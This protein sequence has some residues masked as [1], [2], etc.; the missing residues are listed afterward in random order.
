MTKNAAHARRPRVATLKEAKKTFGDLRL[1]GANSSQ[2][3]SHCNIIAIEDAKS[4]R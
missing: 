4:A 1:S 3:L 2:K